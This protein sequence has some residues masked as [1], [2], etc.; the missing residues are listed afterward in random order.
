MELELGVQ[1]Y[2]AFK[3]HGE[4]AYIE[5][6]LSSS[7]ASCEPSYALFSHKYYNTI[8]TLDKEK[9]HD[10]VFIG[11]INN[12][13][14]RQWVIEFAKKYMTEKSIFINT[15]E[16]PAWVK[17]GSFDLS[18]THI[19]FNPRF[20]PNNQSREIQY[21]HVS[22]NM[23]YFMTLC[24][25]TYVLCP[26]GIDAPWSFRFY[27]TLMCESIPLV[28]SWHHTYRT[29]EESTIPYKYVLANNISE[30]NPAVNNTFIKEN[31]ELFVKYHTL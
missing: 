9:K 7:L 6:G 27:E 5:K 25:S 3:Y 21:R 11:S 2:M 10:Y 28:E 16:D 20:Q 4:E 15:D 14:R 8:K 30:H 17:L 19:G 29:K 13:P 24:N 12:S 26:G 23:F 31:T 22:E 18:N 1:F